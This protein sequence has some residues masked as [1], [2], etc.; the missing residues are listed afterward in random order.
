MTVFKLVGVLLRS[1]FSP[2]RLLGG[3]V[4]KNPA[5]AI[6]L[7]VAIVY[8]LGAVLFSLG[9]L[10]MNLGQI[11]NGV[12]LIH[13]LLMYSFVYGLFMSILFALIR[14]NGSI[15]QYRDYEIL[16]PLPIPAFTV[17]MAKMIVMM[18]F[19]YI[20]MIITVGPVMFA[21]Y[22][23]VG[24]DIVSILFFLIAFIVMPLLPVVIFSILSL[25]ISALT[26]K[27]RRSK[28][29][30]TILLLVLTVG[31]M[32][33]SFAMNTSAENPLL[34]QQHFIEGFSGIYLPIQWYVDAIATHNVLSLLY[35]IIVSVVPFFGFLYLIR[36]LVV[37]TNQKGLAT[38][39]KKHRKAAKSV[40]RPTLQT[41]LMKEWKKFISNPMYTMNA[42][43]GPLLSLL[44]GAAALI[45]RSQI[46]DVL[47]QITT[48]AFPIEILLAAAFG[49]PASMFYT[50]GISL[51]LEGKNFWVLKS[52]PIDVKDVL[53]SKILFNFIFGFFVS[54]AGLLLASFAL[55]LS[56]MAFLTTTLYLATLVMLTS[57]ADMFINLAFP[58]MQFQNDIEIIKQSLSAVISIFGNMAF[59]ILAGGL[60]Y[61][62]FM[63]VSATT[64]LLL[65]SM[66]NMTFFL[67]F[68]LI[69]S[70][71]GS[72]M[73][74]KIRA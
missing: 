36:N 64:I 27:L 23:Q 57:T 16:A 33:A 61:L 35:L 58:R 41:L 71:F 68:L 43:I 53:F 44:F 13:V 29:F 6:L 47:T 12:G 51:S 26:A 28:I 14:A 65:A 20:S 1:S 7:G 11:L 17:L 60:A 52:L 10:F 34:S 50:S 54:F 32:I 22:W 4:K 56:M 9:Y 3:D 18:I 39:T 70:R 66:M 72:T 24:F 19:I 40:V 31:L 5:K 55:Q 21:Y 45:F 62:L 46:A 74:R 30:T 69:L 63:K 59:V 67:L 38:Y 73:Y 2:R 25:L 8:A 15:F 48:V 49:F 42:G 37:K